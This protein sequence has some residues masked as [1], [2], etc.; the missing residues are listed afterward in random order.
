MSVL[1]TA[2]RYD[3]TFMCERNDQCLSASAP[4]TCQLPSG[5]CSFPDP[6]CPTPGQRYDDTAGSLAN[7]CVEPA[8]PV[9]A[10]VAFDPNTC[11]TDFTQLSVDTPSRYRVLPVLPLTAEYFDYVTACG[12]QKPG[13]THIAIIE[14][15]AEAMTVGPL[16]AGSGGPA[17]VYVGALQSQ[18]A[19]GLA[20]GWIHADGS[21]VAATVWAASEPDDGDGS[22]GNHQEQVAVLTSGGRLNDIALK[23]HWPVLCEC[24]GKTVAPAFTTLVTGYR[25]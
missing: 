20:V 1:A 7:Q 23:M 22:E 3:G 4:G 6:L 5:L 8:L 18:T 19:T 10:A 21:P 11:P 24:D 9:D 16:A 14:T 2:C 25:D 12:M 15:L 13:V 17:Q